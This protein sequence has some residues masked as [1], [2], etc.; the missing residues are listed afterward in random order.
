MSNELKTGDLVRVKSGGPVMT[1]AFKD[2]YGRMSCVWFNDKKEHKQ[3]F[4]QLETL[5]NAE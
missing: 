1:A 2:D 5:T 3:E 4:F